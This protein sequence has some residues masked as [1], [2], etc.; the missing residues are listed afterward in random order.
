MNCSRWSTSTPSN[1]SCV[2]PRLSPVEEDGPDDAVVPLA[3]DEFESACVAAA[4]ASRARK[5]DATSR[6]K[7]AEPQNFF[8]SQSAMRL[9]AAGRAHARDERS[10]RA[11]VFKLIGIAIVILKDIQVRFE[12]PRD[13]L[14]LSNSAFKKIKRRACPQ[15]YCNYIDGGRR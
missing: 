10:D 2:L 8:V 5:L 7:G 15:Q 6:D 13:G 3:D 12:R 9:P 4:R 11:D 14:I 1:L